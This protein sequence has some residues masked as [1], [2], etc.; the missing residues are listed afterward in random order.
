M[1]MD[2]LAGERATAQFDVQAMKVYLAGGQREHEIA[3]RMAQ[4]VANDPVRFLRVPSRGWLSCGELAWG[5][6]VGIGVFLVG[7]E[8]EVKAACAFSLESDG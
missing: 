8:V 6:L 1:A 2:H 3:T 7:L 5:K 4:L